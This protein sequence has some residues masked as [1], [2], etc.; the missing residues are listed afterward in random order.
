MKDKQSRTIVI[1]RAK[2]RPQTETEMFA[3][4]SGAMLPFLQLLSW[5]LVQQMAENEGAEWMPHTRSPLAP[6]IMRELVAKGAFPGAR[7]LGKTWLIR[8]AEFTAHVEQKGRCATTANDNEEGDSAV[9]RLAADM[10]Y[11]MAPPDSTKG[12]KP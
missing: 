5:L 10:G 3:L 6:R 8:R 1:C 2:V 9:E 12:S 4:L 11:V 7:K